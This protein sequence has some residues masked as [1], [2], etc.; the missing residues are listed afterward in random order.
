MTKQN[1]K[2]LVIFGVL[3]SASDNGCL[4]KEA[5]GA[6]GLR[7]VALSVAGNGFPHFPAQLA[8]RDA[9]TEVDRSVLTADPPNLRRK[10]RGGNGYERKGGEERE[11]YIK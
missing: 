6:S 8:W 2:R 4:P 3:Y 5:G 11:G 1:K 10:G 9:L 7:S